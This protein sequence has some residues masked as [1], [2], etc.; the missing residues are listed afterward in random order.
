MTDTDED[1]KETYSKIINSIPN[2]NER[3]LG[4]CK[5]CVLFSQV[6][7]SSFETKFVIKTRI[8]TVVTD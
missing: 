3:I 4:K 1:V 6:S 7:C 5:S 2:L 8:M